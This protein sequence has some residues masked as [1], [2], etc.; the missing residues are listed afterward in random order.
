MKFSQF[1]ESA[2][3]AAINEHRD[4]NVQDSFWSECVIDDAK[5]IGALMG[6]EIKEIYWSGFWSQGDGACFTGRFSFVKGIEKAVK[7]YAPQDK[8]LYRIAKEIQELFRA[9][10]YT[11]YGKIEHRGHYNHSGCLSAEISCNWDEKGRVDE[12]EW[13]S[14]FRDFADW[15]YR[16]LEKE[17]NYLTSDEAVAERLEMSDVGFEAEEELMAA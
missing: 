3:A 1:S 17:Y 6:I 7:E 2:K 12:S 11:A 8:E 5:A 15:I 13:T 4:W 9:S 16:Q 10:F 14:V